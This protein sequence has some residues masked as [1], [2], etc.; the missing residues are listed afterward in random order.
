MKA[1]FYFNID[2]VGACNLTC[3]SCPNGNL[4]GAVTNPKGFMQP[5]LLQK[6]IT[7]AK[8]EYQISGVGLFNWYEPLL[9]PQL[10][11]LIKIVKDAGLQCDLSSNLN[12]LKN[13]EAI[14]A[15]NPNSIRIS[16]SGFNQNTYKLTH[17]G[18]DVE[19]VKENMQLLADAIKS[20][21][22]KT[23]THV[24]Y[25][26]YLGNLDEEISLKAYSEKLG[27]EFKPV[28][29]FFMPLEKLMSYGYPELNEAKITE[30]D[31]A[32]ID[33]LAIPL[34]D[35]LQ[36]AR[37]RKDRPCKLKDSQMTMDCQGRVQLCCAVFDS[38]RFTLANFLDHSKDEFQEKK[39]MNEMCTK[40]M[41][42]GLHAY[43]TYD[44]PNLNTM[45]KLR[46]F[47]HYANAGFA[48]EFPGVKGYLKRKVGNL[49]S[50]AK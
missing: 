35:M 4:K 25:H 6:I 12:I 29:A 43:A 47:N 48:F 45:A 1:S 38:T 10:P 30:E 46:I 3:P 36:A 20:T 16:I 44:V 23:K 18:G 13:P 5:D 19:K 2:I 50:S 26:R 17:Q 15:A 31:K 9:H 22:S 11:A 7:K 14:V 21:N 41:D 40:C 28:W 42:R 24:L 39:D 37:L 49:L 8:A 27:F 32:I 34:K 33:R